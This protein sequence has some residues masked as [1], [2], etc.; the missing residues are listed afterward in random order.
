MLNFFKA[1]FFLIGL[2]IFFSFFLVSRE[3]EDY[4]EEEN[5]IFEYEK[6]KY[7]PLIVWVF[8][9]SL[10]I[11]SIVS[12]NTIIVILII[13][14][15]DIVVMMIW[16]YFKNQKIVFNNNVFYVSNWLKKNF[17]FKFEDIIKAEYVIGGG[18]LLHV[19]ANKKVGFSPLM[20]NYNWVFKKLKE[21]KI[22]LVDSNNQ[23]MDIGW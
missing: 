23:K 19:L 16:L 15:V 18:I 3:K 5:I 21:K 17:E 7:L 20:T 13:G 4:N 12:K 22:D 11:L 14:I 8:F 9:S 6:F 2:K 1:I 10:L